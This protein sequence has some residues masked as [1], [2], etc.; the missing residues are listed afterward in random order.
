MLLYHFLLTEEKDN[1]LYPSAWLVG[2]LYI[3]K[4]LEISFI[5]TI[6]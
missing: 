6:Y 1:L 3:I 4:N 2:V 5:F